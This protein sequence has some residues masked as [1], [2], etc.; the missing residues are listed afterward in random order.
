MV[1]PS[2][3]QLSTILNF[4]SIHPINLKKTVYKAY[5][6]IRKNVLSLDEINISSKV[7][8]LSNV[9]GLL[10]IKAPEEI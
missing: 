5:G 9:L 7:I 2:R 8:V 6:H 3:L 4:S 10:G 1:K